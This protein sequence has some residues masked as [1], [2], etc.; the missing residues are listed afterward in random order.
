[1]ELVKTNC[2]EQKTFSVAK[3]F[4]KVV[5]Y[6]CSGWC[7]RVQRIFVNFLRFLWARKIRVALE[8]IE[9]A[10]VLEREIN[11]F[12]LRKYSIYYFEVNERGND[13]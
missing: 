1:M 11:I 3:I 6:F 4:Q 10:R 7:P 2:P 12:H 5:Q 9:L 8:L 13:G